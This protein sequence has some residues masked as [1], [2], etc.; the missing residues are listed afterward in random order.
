M[1]KKAAFDKN[2]LFIGISALIVI[3]VLAVGMYLGSG[4]TTGTGGYEEK[5]LFG[6]TKCSDGT[7]KSSCSSRLLG[8]V[9]AYCDSS[10]VLKADAVRCGC[11]SGYKVVNGQCL[12]VCS[13]GTVV[14][15]CSGQKPY[16]CSTAKV[17]ESRASQ[18]GCLPGLV[19]SGNNCVTP[20]PTPTPTP[21]PTP[22]P[23]P[24]KTLV[25]TVVGGSESIISG[26][27]SDF[28]PLSGAIVRASQF[29]RSICPPA[30]DTPKITGAD[31]KATFVV[32]STAGSTFTCIVS[33]MYNATGTVLTGG[34]SV[35]GVA[36]TPLSIF[37]TVGQ[38]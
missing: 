1:A 11:A 37:Y 36:G 13:D 19:V 8:V 10:C 9:R 4:G 20:T 28:P 5:G 35:A 30:W 3:I 2:L 18:C 15:A 24:Q 7:L 23:V 33:V 31:G 16:F 6:C 12:P 14:G 22:T 29:G 26:S 21:M 17:L 34:G 38:P 27:L 25:V 32:N